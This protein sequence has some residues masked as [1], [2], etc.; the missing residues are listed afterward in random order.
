VLRIGGALAIRENTDRWGWAT[1][2]YYVQ[3]HF[4]MCPCEWK[5]VNSFQS[6]MPQ[7]IEDLTK[8]TYKPGMDFDSLDPYLK[9]WYDVKLNANPSHSTVWELDALARNQKDWV[10]CV[11]FLME[12]TLHH[13]TWREAFVTYPW[14]CLKARWLSWRAWKRQEP[15]GASQTARSTQDKG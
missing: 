15:L 5:K 3:N 8:R 14:L 1:G 4:W 9:Q 6:P 7:F 10:R 13:W 11:A 12:P 2:R